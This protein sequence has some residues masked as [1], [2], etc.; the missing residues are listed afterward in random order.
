[1]LDSDQNQIREGLGN[2]PK[3]LC[4]ESEGASDLE[5]VEPLSILS[6][7]SPL[8]IDTPIPG[9]ALSSHIYFSY[10]PLTRALNVSE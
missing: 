1:M 8:F 3:F 4:R 9:I 5:S 10:V 7:H 2:S 6:S